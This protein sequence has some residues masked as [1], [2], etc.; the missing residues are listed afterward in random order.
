M[1][2]I[3]WL[4]VGVAL[5]YIGYE[6]VRVISL[7]RAGREMAARAVAYQRDDPALSRTMLVLG[8]STAV[9]VGAAPRES[10]PARLANLIGASVENHAKSGAHTRVLK[11]QLAQAKR[12]G[13]D[14]ILIQAGANDVI[15]FGTPAEAERELELVLAGARK[16]SNRVVLLTSGKIGDAPIFPWVFRG[17]LNVRTADLR[18]RFMR[19]AEQYGAVY[20]DI[21]ARS[22]PFGTDPK[23]YYAP[24]FLHLSGEGYAFWFDIVEE[25]VEKRW[26]ELTSD[27][28]I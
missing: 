16:L 9:G 13:Y 7:A 21:Y 20:V 23:R 6:S 8:D 18:E 25:Y 1:R 15:F 17:Y 19:L 3:T 4:I 27:T 22:N 11:E 28:G 24:D 5:A 26:P 12:G 2:M 10:V 14:L